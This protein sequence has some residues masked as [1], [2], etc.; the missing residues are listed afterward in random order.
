MSEFTRLIDLR[1]IGDSPVRLSA[2]AEERVALARRF[3]LVA[4]ERLE[5]VV[6][7]VP[8]AGG[9]DATGRLE[10]AIVQ[11]CAVS[12]EDLPVV[13]AEP[14]KLRFVPASSAAPSPDE[15]IE[16]DAAALD[17]I[18]FTGTQFDLGEA[19]A[20][21]LALAIDPFAVGPAAEEAR[22]RAGIVG[23]GANSPFAALK[24]KFD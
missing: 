15:E 24:G 16:L 9:V 22:R 1:G 21:T 8:E 19:L 7:L 14:V 6:E 13:I 23:E 17:E 2:T 5:A 3:E 4:V 20:Q 12:G 11:S 10:A 18:E